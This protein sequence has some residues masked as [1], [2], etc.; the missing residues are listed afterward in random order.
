MLRAVL[1]QKNL[2]AEE[3]FYMQN[4]IKLLNKE[5]KNNKAKQ[6]KKKKLCSIHF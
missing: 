5:K 4:V 3:Y 2:R 1:R 6:N